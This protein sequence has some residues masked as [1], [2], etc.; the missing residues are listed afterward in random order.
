MYGILGVDGGG[1]SADRLQ[2][3]LLVL[4]QGVFELADQ[5]LDV[6]RHVVEVAAELGDLVLA[7]DL[8]ANAELALGDLAR[9]VGEL[10]ERVD[11][12]A[13][14]DETETE[15]HQAGDGADH[16]GPLLHHPDRSKGD[17]CRSLENDAPA[18]GMGPVPP[19]RGPR[20]HRGSVGWCRSRSERGV[21]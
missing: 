10:L 5:R 8:G 2:E 12:A 14:E 15:G 4:P 9:D 19:N 6:L 7:A 1:Q 18:R 16:Q 21:G 20:R 17:G 13:T 11:H 3:E